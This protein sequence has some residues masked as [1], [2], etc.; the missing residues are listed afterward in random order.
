MTPFANGLAPQFASRA[1]E[2]TVGTSSELGVYLDGFGQ[3]RG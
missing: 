3:G 2:I 1:T